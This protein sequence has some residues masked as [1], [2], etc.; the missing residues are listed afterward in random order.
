MPK[1]GIIEMN[2]NHSGAHILVYSKLARKNISGLLMK[3]VI[4]DYHLKYADA[5]LFQYTYYYKHNY[6]SAPYNELLNFVRTA[7]KAPMAK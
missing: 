3:K 2:S 4:Y 1:I 5:E 7:Q 6:K